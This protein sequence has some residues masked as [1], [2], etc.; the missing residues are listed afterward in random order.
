MLPLIALFACNKGVT[1]QQDEIYSRHLQRKVQLTVINTPL[2]DDRS[3]LH[4]LIINDGQ[5]TDHLRL[6]ALTDSLYK[7]KVIQPLLV[8]A[9]HA[10]DRMQEYGVAGKPDYEGRGARAAYY[11]DFINNE[12][13][14]FIKKKAGVRKFRSV[15]I[16]GCSLGGLSAFDIGWTHAKTSLNYYRKKRYPFKYRV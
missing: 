13:Y 12:L 1:Q 8:V 15:V 6:K 9:V 5:E 3:T 16:A 7:T 2:P 14:P 4:L 10:G 11:D